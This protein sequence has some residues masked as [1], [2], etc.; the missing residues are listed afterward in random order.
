MPL[1]HWSVEG[2][3]LCLVASSNY[4]AYSEEHC[5]IPAGQALGLSG[6]CRGLTSRAVRH[7][8][9]RVVGQDRKTLQTG[10]ASWSFPVPGV[11]QGS[12]P[13]QPPGASNAPSC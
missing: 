4:V 9:R 8:S 13:R 11:L 6:T 5:S 12:E 2:T 1:K 3:S 7:F 10:S